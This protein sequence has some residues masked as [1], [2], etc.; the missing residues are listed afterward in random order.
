MAIFFFALEP[1]PFRWNRNG[2]LG[3]CL[4]AFS[5]REPGSTSLE[6]ALSGQKKGAPTCA[7]APQRSGHCRVC[8]QTVVLVAVPDE[9]AT[10]RRV[11]CCRRA[12]C[13]R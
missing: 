5:L 4:D 12:R 10:G 8:A 11:T 13:A 6:N 7:G 1:L 2:A 3:S 9:T